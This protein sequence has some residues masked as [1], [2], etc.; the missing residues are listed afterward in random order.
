MLIKIKIFFN[1]K[2]KFIF[3]VFI[4]FIIT[5]FIVKKIIL[6]LCFL[7]FILNFFLF[8]NKRYILAQWT[9]ILIYLVLKLYF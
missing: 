5:K 1:L 8:L 3:L 2:A 4:Y 9:Y 6:T 7:I